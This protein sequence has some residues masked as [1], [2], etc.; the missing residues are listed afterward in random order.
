VSGSGTTS[1]EGGENL[2]TAVEATNKHPTQVPES[3]IKDRFIL[4][5]AW[6]GWVVDDEKVAH[7]V[8]PIEVATG[9]NAGRRIVILID[10]TPMVPDIKRH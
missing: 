2:I 1:V 7:Y 6:D 8:S 9:H 10:F 3:A 4:E 5:K